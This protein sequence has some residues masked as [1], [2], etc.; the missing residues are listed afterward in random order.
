MQYWLL[1]QQESADG[2]RYMYFCNADSRES[3]KSLATPFL[4]G[5]PDTFIVTP[6]NNPGDIV[7]LRINI[8]A[9]S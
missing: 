9:T 2:V 5:D 7:S 8:F 4:Y 6:L 3:A 1:E